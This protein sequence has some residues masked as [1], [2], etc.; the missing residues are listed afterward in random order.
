MVSAVWTTAAAAATAAAL[1]AA[2]AAAGLLLWGGISMRG[3]QRRCCSLSVPAHLPVPLSQLLSVLP[4]LLQQCQ[5]A[6]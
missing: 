6:G 3:H 4:Q 5:G 2:V 1:A